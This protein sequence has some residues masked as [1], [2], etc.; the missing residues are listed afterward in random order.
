MSTVA[1]CLCLKILSHE[2]CT[3]FA[4]FANRGWNSTKHRNTKLKRSQVCK[5]VRLI[6]LIIELYLW[7]TT[8]MIVNHDL[9]NCT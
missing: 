3:T 7:R 1:Q 6:N 9:R 4:Y 8:T 2:T 5:R